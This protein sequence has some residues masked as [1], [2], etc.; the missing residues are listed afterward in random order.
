MKNRSEI[1]APTPD[2]LKPK[3]TFKDLLIESKE[4]MGAIGSRLEGM[5]NY[6]NLELLHLDYDE[7]YA[8]KQGKEIV[9]TVVIV[10]KNRGW[11]TGNG[12]LSP[13]SHILLAKQQ[14][15]RWREG[16]WAVPMG[17]I[18]PEKDGVYTP[19]G[20]PLKNAKF[21]MAADIGT[22]V[23]KA[24]IREEAEEI[25]ITPSVDAVMPI[26]GSFRDKATGMIVH[27]VID[28]IFSVPDE[29]LNS[30]ISAELPNFREHS[31]ARWFPVEKTPELEGLSDETK[32]VLLTALNHI[33]TKNAELSGGAS[34]D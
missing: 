25:D 30:P 18:E 5:G 26:A 15:G 6:E 34:G 16:T 22:A 1:P 9:A 24:A 21:P 3:Q 20:V 23:R 19:Y 17:K 11:H 33:K 28:D 8:P 10:Q 12:M 32:F 27:V 7:P 4:V 29:K 13:G 31:E 14:E 2:W